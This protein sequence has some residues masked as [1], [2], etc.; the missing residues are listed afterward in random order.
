MAQYLPVL[1]M[2]VLAVVFA[3]GSFF[4]NRLLAPRRASDSLMMYS[5]INQASV[6]V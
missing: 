5:S 2:I 3:L 4:A 6:I 1:A